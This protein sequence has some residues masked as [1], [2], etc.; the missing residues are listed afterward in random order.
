MTSS[1][2]RPHAAVVNRAIPKPVMTLEG[3]ER[4]KPFT[5]DDSEE[6]NIEEDVAFHVSSIGY[7]PDGEH[8]I[9]G[10]W[11]KTQVF[12]VAVSR[13]GR[14][15]V[16]TSGDELKACGVG[17]GVVATF[18]PIAYID[19]SADSTLLAGVSRETTIRIWSLVTGKLVAG[20]F[21]IINAGLVG[22]VRLSQD[23]KKLAVMSPVGRSIE[24]W[25]VQTQKF[26]FEDHETARII[27]YAPVFWTTKD[28]TIVAAFNFKD[29]TAHDERSMNSTFRRW[30][31]SMFPS[32][33]T[34]TP[35]MV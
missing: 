31:L 28:E 21:E 33:G 22:A 8:M 32:T 26:K 29:E 16:I 12:A 9:S 4:S 11:D 35:S 23:S 14:W 34:L 1:S 6:D 7:F 2:A 30:R 13:N 27:T 17:T 20:P 19:I 25:D 10:S 18:H 5:Q 15:F 24:A 3:H